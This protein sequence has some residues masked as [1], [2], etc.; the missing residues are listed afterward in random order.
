MHFGASIYEESPF[1]V[2]CNDS[3]WIVETS[4]P[5][6]ECENSN[7]DDDTQTLQIIVGGVGHVE[8]NKNDGTIYCAYHTK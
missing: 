5:N 6:L 2:M 1:R 4:L 3:I 8:I 7:C